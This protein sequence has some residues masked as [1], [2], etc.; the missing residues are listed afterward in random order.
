MEQ[1]KKEQTIHATIA[2]L[3]KATPYFPKNISEL[4]E[5]DVVFKL[6]P[7]KEIIIDAKIK[8]EGKAKPKFNLDDVETE[9]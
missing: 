4:V 2:Y 1:Y 8:Y 6:P 9:I 5:Q 3:G 7:K